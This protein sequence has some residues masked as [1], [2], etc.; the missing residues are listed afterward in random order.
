[1]PRP[2]LYH[3]LE[4]V[5]AWWFHHVLTSP[6]TSVSRVMCTMSDATSAVFTGQL[7]LSRWLQRCLTS[8]KRVSQPLLSIW[9]EER[10]EGNAEGPSER[11][12]NRRGGQESA[13]WEVVNHVFIFNSSSDKTVT[14]FISLT[15]SGHPLL[16]SWWMLS[17]AADQ[18]ERSDRLTT[19]CVGPNL[20]C[21]RVRVTHKW[22]KRLENPNQSP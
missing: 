4:D 16:Y 15:Y 14:F 20:H 13:Q 6:R 19:G 21:E 9:R 18:T 5:P 22:G 12:E 8:P 11:P 7:C 1:M 3:Q 10:R 2:C 17:S